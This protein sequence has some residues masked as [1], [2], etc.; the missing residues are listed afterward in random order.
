MAGRTVFGR[1]NLF[2]SDHPGRELGVIFRRH[3]RHIGY[4]ISGSQVSGGI[5]VAI[6]APT[7]A[8]RLSLLDYNHLGHVAVTTDTANASINVDTV[9]EVSE[10]GQ[11]VYS[12]PLEGLRISIALP[13]RF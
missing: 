12:K 5:A 13:H 9:I 6:Q 2:I 4:F 11:V 10:I 3:P 1:G 8:E 7:H